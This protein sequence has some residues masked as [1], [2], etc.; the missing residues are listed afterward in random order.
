[1]MKI[2]C[3]LLL[4]TTYFSVGISQEP[5][6]HYS[7][8]GYSLDITDDGA[9]SVMAID[10]SS[11]KIVVAHNPDQRMTP[12]SLTKL[13]T[14]GAVLS[15]LDADYRYQTSFYL[16]K[17]NGQNKLVVVGS[18]DPTFGSERFD[19]TQPDSIFQQLYQRLKSKGI[20]KLNALIVDN[21]CYSGIRQP[22]K[23]LWED[24]GNYYGAV[25]NGLTYRENTFYMKMKSP[26]GV[27]EPVEIV[28]VEPDPGVDFS[29]LVK[30]A[31]NNKDSAYIYGHADMSNWYVSGTIPQGR[32]AFS[33]K[34]ALP[35]PELTF[36]DELAN[37]LNKKGIEVL[38]IGKSTQADM[39]FSEPIY[40]HF[41][42]PLTE[43]VSVIN[44]TSHNLYADHL[45][46]RLAEHKYGDASWDKG[47][48]SVTEFWHGRIND[49]S[50]AFY[51]GSGLSPFNAIS[52]SDMVE[53]LQVMHS[54]NNSEVFKQSLSI[55]G[56]DG[57]LKSILRDDEFKG[58]FIGK[59]GS[60][61]GVLGYCGYIDT[62]RGKTLAFCIIANR[63]TESYKE[64]RGNMEMLM[65]EIIS[66]N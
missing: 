49:F 12:A 11:G 8:D 57:T 47:V 23:R 20:L 33:I 56:I 19:N 1:M 50:G 43:I 58:Y 48:S 7:N 25:P 36:A 42:P 10:M 32:D 22:S 26:N 24:I 34:G 62:K 66:Q 13:I 59:S 16:D 6:R 53:V 38:N 40:L 60:F 54:G 35:H 55:A 21:S 14:T 44:K 41:S 5:A 28:N 4:I 37:F 52:A 2:L 17:K 64:L 30:S 9:L 15:E 61:N 29:C 46:F 39:S 51:D 45:L 27:E 31:A 65:K 18:G 63:F 3:T